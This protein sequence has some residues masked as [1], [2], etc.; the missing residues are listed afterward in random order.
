MDNKKR[1]L[2]VIDLYT[3]QNKT[4]SQI[5]KILSIQRRSVYRILNRLSI[6]LKEHITTECAICQK[7]LANNSKGRTR[8]AT[9]DTN[10]RRYRIRKKAVDYKGCKCNRC[11]WT[12]DISGF[13]FHHSDPKEKEFEISAKIIASMSWDKVI[14][15]LDKCELLCALCHRL[16]H[17]G[18]Q[19]EFFLKEVE[20]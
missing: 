5:S 9:C 12:G 15:E 14:I 13:D 20:K 2:E 4:C 17:S 1:E 8:C 7:H 6:P 3:Q 18:Y 19:N 10:V 11:N 16:E